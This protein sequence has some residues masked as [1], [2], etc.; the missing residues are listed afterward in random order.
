MFQVTGDFTWNFNVDEG[1]KI[2]YIKLIPELFDKSF[3]RE[4]KRDVL[5]MKKHFAS[6]EK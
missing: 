5:R 4:E 1:G 2:S 3:E 6:N